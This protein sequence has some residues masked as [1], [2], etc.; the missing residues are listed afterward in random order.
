VHTLS[1]L[2][3][4][5]TL[6]IFLL[7]NYILDSVLAGELGKALCATRLPSTIRKL[8][9]LSDRASLGEFRSTKS[10]FISE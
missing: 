7:L 4:S 6:V 9:L 5:P 2:C 8:H 10:T 1:A 3:F